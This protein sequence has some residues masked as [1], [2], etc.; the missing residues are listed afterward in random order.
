MKEQSKSREEYLMERQKALDL[1][2]KAGKER[3]AYFSQQYPSSREEYLK[4]FED[5]YGHLRASKDTK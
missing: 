4:A 1:I 3:E 2:K 5:A